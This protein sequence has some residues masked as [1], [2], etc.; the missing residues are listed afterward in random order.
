M[1]DHK[2]AA[3]ELAGADS[4]ESHQ[5]AQKAERDARTR[6][7]NKEN[8]LFVAEIRATDGPSE[9]SDS[10]GGSLLNSWVSGS[11]LD[12]GG[13]SVEASS[14]FTIA[15][16][17]KL[18]LASQEIFELRIKYRHLKNKK[19]RVWEASEAQEATIEKLSANI[20]DLQADNKQVELQLAQVKNECDGLKAECDGLKARDA[21][22]RAQ[23]EARDAK[24]CELQDACDEQA[25]HDRSSHDRS[26]ADRSARHTEL[27]TRNISEQGA[28][29][30]TLRAEIADLQ[31]VVAKLRMHLS[32]QADIFKEQLYHLR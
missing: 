31:A 26:S 6:A 27:M 21:D 10:S 7:T 18:E 11:G 30:T 17:H 25:S 8:A 29:E 32:T 5:R 19:D 3:W 15:P 2:L 28:T 12:G 9:S 13:G 1:S 22:Q 14:V 16:E 23:I 20:R 24:L 4:I